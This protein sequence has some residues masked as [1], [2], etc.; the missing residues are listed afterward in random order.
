ML[1]LKKKQINA[2]EVAKQAGVSQST[3]SRV[4]T[5]GA[6][7]SE[8]ARR[9]VLETAKELGYRPNA[10]ARGL[11]TNKTNIIGLVMRE[12]Q[13]P[14]YPEV[15]E[16]FTKGLRKRGYQV[17]FVYAE[18]DEL[19]HDDISQF[20]EYN[21]EGVIV[22]DALL[23]SK[24]VS[25]FTENSI[26]VLL[27]NRYAKDFSG[28]VVCCDNYSAG[29][30]IGEYLLENEHRQFA[31]IAGDTNTSTSR[32]RERGFREALCHEGIEPKVE[33]GNYTYEGGYQ[34]ALQLLKSDP[35]LDAI[36]CA[37]DIMALGAVDAV[38]SLGLT[39]PKDVS[40]M[41]VDDIVMA[42][43]PPYS[44]TTWQQPVDEMIEASINIL[45]GEISGE[46]E[47]PV[48]I[49]LPGKLIERQSVSTF[50]K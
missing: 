17:L 47:G 33:V 27:F 41:G 11:I 37:N 16:K 46:N 18:K 45:L 34:A 25:H 13:N 4:F 22:T 28:H 30:K 32:D 26:P 23:S 40:I 10:L 42:S 31:Y 49:L 38:K 12:I 6:S 9:R 24:V 19:Q 14:F 2:I 3:V 50:K 7:V 35:Q 21:V 44:L 29:K 5:P 39:I 36:F 43:L 20:L 15:L 1:S 8:K 48:S